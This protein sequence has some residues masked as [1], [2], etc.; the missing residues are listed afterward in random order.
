MQIRVG[1]E[2]AYRCPQPTPMILVLGSHFSRASDMAVP[3]YLTTTP[4]VPIAFYR[5]SFGN[6]CNRLTAPAG[7]F[8]LGTDGVVRD[9]G[10]PDVIVPEARQIPV[11]V[12]A[13][14]E[15]AVPL[16]GSF[17]GF[18]ADHIGMEVAVTITAAPH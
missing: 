5:D 10:K 14:P 15:E 16:S 8:T 18:P 7:R 13:V 6:W 2:M 4:T 1:F 11:A 9:S 17:L 12:V 3:D